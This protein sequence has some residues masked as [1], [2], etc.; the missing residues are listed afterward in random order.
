LIPVATGPRPGSSTNACTFPHW[1]KQARIPA[2]RD[3]PRIARKGGAF[4]SVKT[5]SSARGSPE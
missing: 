1:V 5:T 2:K 4:L 3:E